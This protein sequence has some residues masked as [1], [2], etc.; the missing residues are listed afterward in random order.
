MNAFNLIRAFRN[1]E[2]LNGI[3]KIAACAEPCP[4]D[5]SRSNQY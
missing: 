2:D 4:D 3:P 5:R 1:E